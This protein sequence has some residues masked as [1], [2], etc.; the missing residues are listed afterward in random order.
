M[1][2]GVLQA[3]LS[4]PGAYSL[5]D[6]RHVVKSVL[7]R[8][9]REHAVTAAEVGDLDTWNRARIGVAFV[10]NEARHAESHL[11]QIV[12]RLQRERDAVLLDSQIEVF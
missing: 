1:F 9:R 7:D 11:Q 10:S 12:N 5:K 8:L 6:K 2:V 3:E 4:I